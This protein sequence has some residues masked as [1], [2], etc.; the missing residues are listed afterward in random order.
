MSLFE[1]VRKIVNQPPTF[2]RQLHQSTYIEPYR[3]GH[4]AGA[5]RA[6]FANEGEVDFVAVLA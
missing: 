5:V 3:S 6:G 1:K 2:G 4:E